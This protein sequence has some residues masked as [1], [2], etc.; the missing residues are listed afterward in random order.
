MGILYIG[1]GEGYDGRGIECAGFGEMS[2]SGCCAGIECP[3]GF[4][5]VDR[6]DGLDLSADI[7]GGVRTL[8]FINLG[9][10]RSNRTSGGD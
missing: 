5:L 4:T 3:D 1:T 2:D 6:F 9:D 7:S 8:E 10:S